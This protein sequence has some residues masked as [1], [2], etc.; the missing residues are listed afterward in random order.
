MREGV[1]GMFDSQAMRRANRALVRTLR[2]AEDFVAQAEG[3]GLVAP[4]RRKRRVRKA[5]EAA[6]ASAPKKAKGAKTPLAATPE[7]D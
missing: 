3:M 5:E 6:A 1:R 4:K 7:E 2:F